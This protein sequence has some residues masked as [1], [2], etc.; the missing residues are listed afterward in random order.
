VGYYDLV[1]SQGNDTY[2]NPIDTRSIYATPSRFT[3]DNRSDMAITG[4]PGFAS[5]PI[6]A[7]ASNGTIQVLNNGLANFPGFASSPYARIVAGDFDGDTFT[8]LAVT[9][10]AGW[11]SVP[12]AFSNGAGAFSSTNIGIPDFPRLASDPRSKVFTGRFDAGT[13]SDIALIGSP[14]IGGVALALG[15]SSRGFTYRLYKNENLS[16]LAS[17][18]KAKILSG[19]FNNDGRTDFAI[20]GVPGWTTIPLARSTTTGDFQFT[21]TGVGSFPAKAAATGAEVVVGDFDGDKKADLAV[22][23]VTGSTIPVARSNGDGS[24]QYF[25]ANI[26]ADFPSWSASP[27]A[28][29][30]IG[31]FNGDGRSDIAIQGPS[32]WHSIPVAFGKV[33]G[34]FNIVNSGVANFP[35]FAATPGVEMLVGDYNGDGR[36][37]IALTG[38]SGWSSIP[39]AYGNVDG[40]FTEANIAAG[41]FPDWAALVQPH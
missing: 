16:K 7:P 13:F 25:N 5:I 33:D 31:D 29:M 3:S 39:V 18:P 2:G 4:V 36:S 38:V 34:S 23:G 15:T 10:V 35:V 26:G 8:D 37:D 19:D 17:N 27:G 1:E 24:F 6:A 9:G 22:I 12:V 32:G 28:K 30:L 14:D 40:S 11:Y 21:N 41:S 20:T